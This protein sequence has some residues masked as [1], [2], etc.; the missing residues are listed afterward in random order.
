MTGIIQFIFFIFTVP[1]YMKYD[2]IMNTLGKRIKALRIQSGRKAGDCAKVLGI[3]RAA[4]Y[5]WEA[6]TQIPGFH[7][8]IRLSEIFGASLDWLMKGK[9]NPPAIGP[10]S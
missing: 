8:L 10:S 9:G 5:G 4:F 6:D 2:Q 1:Y 3:S 7:S